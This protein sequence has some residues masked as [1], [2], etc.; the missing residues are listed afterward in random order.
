MTSP[1]PDLGDLAR[2]L[3]QHEAGGRS[4]PAASAAALEQACARLK[5]DL[6][7]LLGSR[8]VSALFRRAL[9]LAHRERP[10]L[11]GVSVDPEP[12]ACFAG[13]AEALAEGSDEEAAEAGAAVLA[14]LLG[15]LVMLLG[16]DLGM[17]PVRK[18]WPQVASSVR[19]IDE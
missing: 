9:H 12:A 18:L 16:E 3:V 19:E 7:D 5:G 1:A 6:A 17:Q 8:G 4:G 10:L 15:L 14:Q 11:A 13:L 2:R